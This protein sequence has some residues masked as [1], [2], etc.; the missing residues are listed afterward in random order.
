[1]LRTAWAELKRVSFDVEN[2]REDATTRDEVKRLI[3]DATRKAE[4]LRDR[5]RSSP[6]G[7]GSGRQRSTRIRLLSLIGMVRSKKERER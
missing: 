6:G 4:D 1:M 5:K 3:I 7:L 2:L